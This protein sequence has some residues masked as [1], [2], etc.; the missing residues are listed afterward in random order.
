M[1]KVAPH[2]HGF[3][4]GRQVMNVESGASLDE[5]VSGSALQ[6]RF[7]KAPKDVP[8]EAYEELTPTLAAGLCNVILEWSP[9]VLILGGSLMN[10]DNGYRVTDIQQVLASMPRLHDLLPVITHASLGDE[11]GLHGA[12]A[13]CSA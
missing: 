11:N 2:A 7:G 5:L 4:P 12:L 10:E 6:Q 13:A 8:R 1:K 3:E 9:E